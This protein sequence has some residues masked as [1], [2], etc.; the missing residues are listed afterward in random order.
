M[1][2]VA[3]DIA[4]IESLDPLDEQVEPC[5]NRHLKVGESCICGIALQLLVIGSLVFGNFIPKALNLFIQ[6]VFHLLVSH[7]TRS[8]SFEESIA[9]IVEGNGIDVISNGVEGGGDCVG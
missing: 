5:A 7:F 1:S 6:M 3:G 9:Y 8:D 4:I 2:Q